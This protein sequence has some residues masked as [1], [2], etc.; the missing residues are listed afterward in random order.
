[1][2]IRI[3]RSTDEKY[4]DFW[5]RVDDAAREV[6][7]WPEWLKERTQQGRVVETNEFAETAS[8]GELQ[9]RAST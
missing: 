8:V 1:M 7:K 3:R 2:K 9:D 4:R 6:A 5:A